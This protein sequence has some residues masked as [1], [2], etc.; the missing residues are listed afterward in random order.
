MVNPVMVFRFLTCVAISAW[1]SGL[2]AASAAQADPHYWPQWR[3]P[4]ATGVA[5]LADPPIQWSEKK[6]IRWKIP[7]PGKG[8]STPIIFGDEIFLTMAAPVGEA[9][10]PVYDN[11]P[12]THDN[13]GVTHNH[14]FSLVAVSRRDGHQLWKKVVRTEFPHEGGHETGSLASNSPVTDGENVYACFGSRGLYCFDLK[15]DLKWQKDLGRMQTLHAHG[16]GSSPV[17]YK[18]FL[19][20]CWDHEGD[21][22]L[23]LFDK[24][25][26]KEVWKV[27]RDEK[28]SWSTP[29]IV[30]EE[31]KPQ[32]V[33]SATKRVRGYDL[34]T[35][36]LLWECAGLSRNV[37]STPVA[38]RGMV[39]AGNSYDWQSMLAIRL[40]GAKGDITETPNLVWK[41]NRLTP[42]VSSPLLYDDT[43]YFIRH[44]QNIISRLE[45]ETGK[46]YGEPLRLPGI[47]DFIFSSPVGAAGRIYITGRDG[48][49]VVLRHDRKNDELAVNR[50]DDVFSASAA[51]VDH[52]LYLRGERFLYCIA[53]PAKQA[54]L[55][56]D[57]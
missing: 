17:L 22:F 21:S 49:T 52:E 14:E 31:G 47:Q 16:E 12:G 43:L 57:R 46:P 6:N 19:I 20:L 38:G 4:L 41:L 30:E 44:N 34:A 33:I 18:D 54:S 7:L 1:A 3:G 28:T 13:V 26:G 48:R 36:T 27:A 2:H 40:K 9:H 37:V 42:Y 5:P 23:Y 25:T 10:K 50:L 29:L 45:P 15:G 24:R 32:I 35:G 39:F 8:H 51:L 53:E 55:S 56:G 11:A